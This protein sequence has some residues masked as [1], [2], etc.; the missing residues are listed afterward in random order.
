MPANASRMTGDRRSVVLGETGK[1]TGF[2]SRG[3]SSGWPCS[4]QHITSS[5]S[6]L[7]S[8][9]T[10]LSDSP[11]KKIGLSVS[12]SYNRHLCRTMTFVDMNSIDFYQPSTKAGLPSNRRP[13]V[14]NLGVPMASGQRKS[15]T[16]LGPSNEPSGR[17][18][19]YDL[20]EL[21]DMT[22]PASKGS[23]D[24]FC[25]PATELNGTEVDAGSKITFFVFGWMWTNDPRYL[26]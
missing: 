17:L 8:P 23:L 19:D 26:I 18:H 16:A 20:I 10:F 12:H 2:A 1:E 9:R 5:S 22:S 14:S 21:L 13:T 4:P 7:P 25:E 24:P 11:A 15:A 6:R 3:D